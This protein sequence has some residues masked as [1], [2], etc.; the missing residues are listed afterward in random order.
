MCRVL[1]FKISRRQVL[2]HYDVLYEVHHTYA[3]EDGG[4]TRFGTPGVINAIPFLCIKSMVFLP[5]ELTSYS[6]PISH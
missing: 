3:F 4:S 1:I 5:E 6:H 2:V